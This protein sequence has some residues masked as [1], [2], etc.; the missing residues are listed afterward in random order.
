VN[1]I[2][3]FKVPVT[4]SNYIVTATV[5]WSNFNIVGKTAKETIHAEIPIP[6]DEEPNK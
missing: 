1:L 2:S 3:C 6:K 5:K 4:A